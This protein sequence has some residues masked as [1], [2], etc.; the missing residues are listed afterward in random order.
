MY[1]SGRW[2]RGMMRWGAYLFLWFVLTYA[3]VMLVEWVR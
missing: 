3:L 2:V 1:G